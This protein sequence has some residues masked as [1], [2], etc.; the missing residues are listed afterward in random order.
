[1]NLAATLVYAYGTSEGVTKAWDTRGRSQKTDLDDKV[2]VFYHGT[3]L[4]SAKKIIKEGLM[5][6]PGKSFQ[7]NHIPASMNG[8]VYVTTQPWIAKMFAEARAKYEKSEPG[9]DFLVGNYGFW[10]RADAPHPDIEKLG[11]QVP[12]IVKIAVPEN[13][14]ATFQQDPDSM[15]DAALL[16]KGII[17]KEYIKGVSV[18]QGDGKKWK[19]FKPEQLAAAAAGRTLYL[20]YYGPMDALKMHLN[21]G[22]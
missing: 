17:P 5:P 10:K 3:V 19:S 6:E 21:A 11:E 7:V 1:M 9:E 14:A 2:K 8:Y 13:V 4:P 16:R 12:A 20:V 18:L 22:K 15:D